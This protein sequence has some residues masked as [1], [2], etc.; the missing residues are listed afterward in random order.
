MAKSSIRFGITNGR[1]ES[2]STWKIWNNKSDVYLASR[3]QGGS[4]KVSFHAKC[5]WRFAFTKEMYLKEKEYN[6][7]WRKDRLI[8][9]WA[10]P[11][12][13]SEGV[14]LAYR[15]ITPW[16]SVRIPIRKTAEN[17]VYIPN[18]PENKAIEIY[19]IITSPNINITG[20]PGKRAMNT[21]LVGSFLIDNGDTIWVVYKEIDN[22]QLNL[23][24][25][26]NTYY[27]NGKSKKDLKSHNLRAFL[28]GSYNDE[29][30]WV[31]DSVVEMKND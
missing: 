9:E 27:F 30:R 11:K 15:I 28:Y 22:P 25:N 8:E 31:Y 7:D 12:P 4:F 24:I 17:I 14:T 13:L 2:A 29:S 23:P 3:S 10:K 18:A 6:P 19:I 26:G 20:W 1:G 16:S 5:N 21:S